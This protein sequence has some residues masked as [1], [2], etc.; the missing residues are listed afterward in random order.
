MFSWR[1]GAVGELMPCYQSIWTPELRCPGALGQHKSRKVRSA[2]PLVVWAL[3]D[4]NSCKYRLSIV[5][6]STV[7]MYLN[8]FS[9]REKAGRYPGVCS[10]QAAE[11]QR[12]YGLLFLRRVDQQY[13]PVPDISQP[14]LGGISL[15]NTVFSDYWVS[16]ACL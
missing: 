2:L 3:L 1:S 7:C 8:R 14:F 10:I 11:Q 9:R 16:S 13:T 4:K 12:E 6:F 15:G 5:P